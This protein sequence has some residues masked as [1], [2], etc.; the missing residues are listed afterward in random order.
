MTSMTGEQQ[1]PQGLERRSPAE[2]ESRVRFSRH[3]SGMRGR[4]MTGQMGLVLAAAGALAGCSGRPA[5][6]GPAPPALVS[7]AELCGERAGPL[8]RYVV[9][10]PRQRH[11]PA[12]ERFSQLAAAPDS[13]VEVCTAQAQYE[14]LARLRCE[15]G[16]LPFASTDEVRKARDGSVGVG[17]RC[18]NVI[19]RYT[20]ECP[21]ESYVIHLDLYMCARAEVPK[22]PETIRVT[23]RGITLRLPRAWSYAIDAPVGISALIRGPGDIRLA[24]D[25]GAGPEPGSLDD[26]A[27]LFVALGAAP[28]ARVDGRSRLDGGDELV[29][30]TDP[31]ALA[32]VRPQADA[33]VV[34]IS[35]VLGDREAMLEH[36][37]KAYE[38]SRSVSSSDHQHVD[39]D[40]LLLGRSDELRV[41]LY[42]VGERH[43]LLPEGWKV[44]IQGDAI[45]AR[46]DTPSKGSISLVRTHM[47]A[48][49]GADARDAAAPAFGRMLQSQSG[50]TILHRS[51]D[52]GAR[53]FRIVFDLSGGSRN[54]GLVRTDPDGGY[55]VFFMS[56]PPEL[57]DEISAIGLLEAVAIDL[58]DEGAA[59]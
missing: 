25:R 22:P 33:G 30:F 10:D 52:P 44:V 20:V 48:S 26:L 3:G 41:L 43:E 15:D 31:P 36:G 45:V 56:G 13:P 39:Y 6:I 21:E 8:E 18:G 35:L 5:P 58:P 4:R 47:S 28:P 38:I 2:P 46:L 23:D 51:W 37:V 24:I 19:D 17:G 1:A 16:S 59:D 27:R 42:P 12:V 7:G 40:E 11:R 54:V 9:V 55:T 34:W 49:A 32:F 14:Y 29:S 57:L 53:R 50:T